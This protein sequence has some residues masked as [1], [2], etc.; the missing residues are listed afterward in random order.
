MQ[1][2]QGQTRRVFV[3]S[4]RFNLALALFACLACPLCS[5]AQQR[6][7]GRVTNSPCGFA[8]QPKKC[9]LRLS[10]VRFASPDARGG[11][12]CHAEVCGPLR[13]DRLISST[14]IPS[15]PC[16]PQDGAVNGL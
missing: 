11:S 4:S 14:V 1:K 3:R 13:P 16:K 12:T 15:S 7:S 5:A 9:I 6:I 10:R 2:R 8:T